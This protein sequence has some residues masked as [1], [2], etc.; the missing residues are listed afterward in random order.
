MTNLREPAGL[1]R[2]TICADGPLLVRGPIEI[3][4][5]TG[6][7][8]PRNRQIIALCRCGFSRLAPFCDGIHKLS[9]GHA[10]PGAATRLE[11]AEPEP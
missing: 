11:T 6:D 2:I 1:T 9:A 10:R 8:L 4:D 7:V 3:V 5:S